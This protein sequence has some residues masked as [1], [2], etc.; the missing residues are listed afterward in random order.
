[1]RNKNNAF[2]ESGRSMVEMLGVLAIIGVL[3]I[4]GL[5]AYST[6]TKRHRANEL[7]NEASKRAT[8]VAGQL[9]QGNTADLGEFAKNS[10]SAAEFATDTITKNANNQFEIAFVT[11]KIPDEA[12]CTTMKEMIGSDS[13][14]KLADDCSKITFN[15][16]LSKHSSSSSN[17]S[18]SGSSGNNSGNN[19]DDEQ[20]ECESASSTA[21]FPN[22]VLD[23]SPYCFKIDPYFYIKT[24]NETTGQLY[25]KKTI[26]KP[27]LWTD[28]EK[29]ER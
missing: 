2:N 27:T 25:Y 20:Q 16:D 23:S 11:N 21:D 10:F 1:M 29:N 28:P 3:S 12:T 22:P 24:L 14:M 19:E 7:I 4:G 18:N 9:M 8:V 5:S 17:S 6:A 13:F 15:A 26:T